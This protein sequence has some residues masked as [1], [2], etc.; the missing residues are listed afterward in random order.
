MSPE[1]EYTRMILGLWT[2]ITARVLGDLGSVPE[3]DRIWVADMMR[4]QEEIVPDLLD[5]LESGDG[6]T[7]ARLAL[8][9]GE[10]LARWRDL[11]VEQS[12]RDS[13]PEIETGRAVREGAAKAGREKGG[14][15]RHP[16]DEILRA[17][18]KHPRYHRPGQWSS[19][20]DE[21]GGALIPRLSGKQVRRILDKHHPE[22]KW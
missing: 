6:W 4:R 8:E 2:E 19:V 7:A 20:T 15:H 9:T 16:P 17:V 18:H 21:V 5:A 10:A 14:K 3:A 11:P 12:F 13:F 22:T 1:E